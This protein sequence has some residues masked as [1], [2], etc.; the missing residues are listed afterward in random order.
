MWTT[1]AATIASQLAHSADARSPGLDAWHRRRQ[2]ATYTMAR[3]AA[4]AR[5]DSHRAM[6]AKR[7]ATLVAPNVFSTSSDPGTNAFS[8]PRIALA[9]LSIWIGLSAW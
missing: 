1:S 2:V 7:P 5:V 3:P 8:R 4:V 9:V 6:P